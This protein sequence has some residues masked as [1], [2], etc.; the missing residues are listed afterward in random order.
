[1]RHLQDI[2]YQTLGEKFFNKIRGKM[3]SKYTVQCE[4]RKD[5]TVV[6]LKIRNE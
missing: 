1:M 2:I 5:E 3:G 6:Y 4:V